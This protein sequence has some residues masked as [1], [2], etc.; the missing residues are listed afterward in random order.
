MATRTR[1]RSEWHR[2]K[3]GCWTCSLGERGMRVRLFEKRR[4]GAFYRETHVPG[5]GRDQAPL[6]TSDK[7]VA[8]RLGRELLANLLTGQAAL[9]AGPLTL[10]VLWDAFRTEC[11][12]YL[13]N[14]PRTRR[15]E[16]L[17][18][19]IL[20]GHF[21]T[22]FDV[23]RLNAKEVG[24][25]N[26]RRLAGGIVYGKDKEGNE[27]RTGTVRQTSVHA[28]LALLRRMIR[29]A[30]T[31]RLPNGQRRLDF[32]P[33][34]G[35]RFDRERNPRR[36]VASVERFQATRNAVQMLEAESQTE[37]DRLRW[38]RLDMALFL[39]E[40]TGRRR[41]AIVGLRWEDFDFTK[42]TVL[43][44]AEHDKKGKEWLVPMPSAFMEQLK[45]FRQRFQ[46]VAGPLFPGV[47]EPKKPMPAEL[48]TQWLAK[49]EAK[50]GLNKLP[51]SLW[52]AYR[53]KFATERMHHPLRA[54]ADAGGW[55][56]VGTLLTCYQ[57]TDEETL[58]AVMGESRKLSER[59]SG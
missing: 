20:L 28:D 41:G 19:K 58:L 14:K 9:P 29:W 5:K 51:G 8:E 34:D 54:V 10:G 45:Q 24:D 55:K 21:G 53:R 25:Y 38:R 37:E 15:D 44:R 7:D 31:Q 11:A 40:A 43:W 27:L 16:A 13:D 46:A 30:T 23:R 36:A 4:D 3:T 57:Q 26:K 52:H 56:D 47:R 42:G 50:A 48:L 17:R 12:A 6:H 49:A 32:N 1:K 33:L 22:G 39:A 2:T 35:L 59:R 18:A